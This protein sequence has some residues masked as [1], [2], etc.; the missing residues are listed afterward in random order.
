M[1]IEYK[2]NFGPEFFFAEGEPYV[3]SKPVEYPISVW[4]GIVNMKHFFPNTWEEMAKEVFDCKP[5]QLTFEMVLEK[6]RETNRYTD[7]SRNSIAVLIS[8][9]FYVVVYNAN[10]VP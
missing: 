1:S 6:I 10:A 8:D 7:S 2:L 3:D 9:E 4:Q 5:E